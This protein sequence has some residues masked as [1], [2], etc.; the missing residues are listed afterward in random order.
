MP[1]P[2]LIADLPPLAAERARM[3][4]DAMARI[5][6]LHLPPGFRVTRVYESLGVVRLDWR[7]AGPAQPEVAR[8]AHQ[9]A[10]AT[11]CWSFDPDGP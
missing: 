6:R 5:A 8:I 1:W 11:D 3:V 4:E 10:V 7:G 9:L 2:W